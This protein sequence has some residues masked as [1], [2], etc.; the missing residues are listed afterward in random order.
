MGEI[1]IAV[2]LG[3][4]ALSAIMIALQLQ[5][6]ARGLERDRRWRQ[7]GQR[8]RLAATR[9]VPPEDPSGAPWVGCG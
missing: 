2:C 6:I 8:Q 3:S 7:L 5:R 9:D 4:L 1:L